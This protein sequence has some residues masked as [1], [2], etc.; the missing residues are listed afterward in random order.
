MPSLPSRCE[1][2]VVGAGPAGSACAQM[3][4]RAGHEVALVDQHAFPRDK[5]CG[6]GLIPDAHAA[7]ARLGVLDEVMALAQ[8]VHHVSCFGSRGG[9]IDVPGRL[10]VLQRRVLDHLLLRAAERAGARLLPPAR[11]EAPLVDGERVVG[12][13]LAAGGA[14]H[15]IGARWVVLATGA[16]PQAM[17]AAGLNERRDPSGVALRGYLRHDGMRDRITTLQIVWHRRLA[18]GYGWIFPLPGGVFNIGAGI[19]GSYAERRHNLR[20]LFEAFCELHADARALVD[21]GHWEGRLEGA[22]LR[23]SLTGAR[24]TR[25]GMLATGEAIG[26]TYAFTGEGIG[27]AMTTGMMAADAIAA[28]GD[29][30]SARVR[31]EAA[32]R[33]LEPRFALYQKAEHVNR[34]PWLTDLVI[35]RARRSPR[36]LR[37]MSGVLEETQNPG[38]LLS[39]RGIGKLMF[40]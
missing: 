4:A 18:G 40:E 25:P 22:P 34:R 16:P 36:I 15:E 21:G 5:T 13:R 3:L 28:G 31:Y 9:R 11:F 7:L 10:A 23:C 35:W 14:A 2:L 19:T 17:I 24:R 29:D 20:Q 26:S 30:A 27:K 32:L 1:V 12:A 38:R 8:P 39:W 37:R 33:E 6:D